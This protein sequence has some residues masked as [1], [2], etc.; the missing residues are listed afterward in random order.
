MKVSSTELPPRQVS[1][2]IE[3]EQERLDRA[4]D[5]AYRRIAGNVNVPGVRRGKAQRSMVERMVGRDRIVEDALEHLL[6]QV[7][8]DAMEQEQVEPYTRP[9]VESVDF[10]P[11]RVKAVVGLAP[12]VELGD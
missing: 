3:V 6:P 5:E 12:K 8:A 2:N 4:I 1:L 7:V 9:R 11:L 10:D